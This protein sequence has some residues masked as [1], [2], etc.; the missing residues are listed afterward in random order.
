MRNFY[1]V[2][3]WN[4]ERTGNSPAYYAILPAKWDREPPI[5]HKSIKKPAAR[6]QAAGFH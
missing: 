6:E 1:A 5:I 4:G 2:S 3:C